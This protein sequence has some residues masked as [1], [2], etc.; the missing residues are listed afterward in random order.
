M[1]ESSSN[2]PRM[3]AIEREPAPGRKSGEPH[4]IVGRR[5]SQEALKRLSDLHTRYMKGVPNGWCVIMKECDLSGLDF[6]NL[7]FSHGH[8]IGCDFT[9]ANLEDSH[10]AGA[11]LFS[12]NFD[13]AN[14]TR[15]D[16]AR[17]DLRGAQFENAE[18]EGARLEGA[19]LRRGAVIRRGASA[20]V[21][22]ENSSFRGARMYGTNMTECKLLD[23]NFDGAAMSG[24][25]LQ[26]ADLRGASFAGAEL[27]GV[28]LSGAN[29]ADADFRRAVLDEATALRG[30]MMRSV[31][32]RTAPGPE[33]MAKI[34]ADHMLWIQTGQ[35]KG[36]RADFARMDLSRT[37]FSRA[38]LAGAVFRE[39]IL[40]DVNFENAFLAAADFTDAILLRANLLGADLRGADLRGAEMKDAR[41][42]GAKTGEL[43]GTSLSTR[44]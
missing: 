43:S 19:D 14:L 7:N 22:K 41:R 8:F 35:Q 42:D 13:G 5:I 30:D 20:P 18:L 40:A 27:K 15:T 10:F 31:K 29:L 11:N 6:R 1:S 28:E 37:D 21:G 24:T 32:P 4:A 9:G 38:V 12:A 34:L 16:F 44:L 2:A 17:A 39:T 33:R 36:H 25:S 26:G 23:A 3:V